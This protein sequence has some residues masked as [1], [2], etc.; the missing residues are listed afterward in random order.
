LIDLVIQGAAVPTFLIDRIAG[1]TGAQQISP[2]PPQAV[3]LRC[4]TRHPEVPALCAGERL[5]F[6][7]IA[8]GRRLADYGLLAMD[9]DSTLITIEC[10]DEVA[11][12]AG[13]KGEVSAI[14]EAAMRGEIDYT[15]SLKRRVGLLAGLPASIL[16]KV[17]EERLRLSTGARELLAAAQTAGLKTLLVSGGFTYFTERL[18]AELRLDAAFSNVLEVVDGQLTG[19]VLGDIVDARGK[20]R[21]VAAMRDSLGLARD[22]VIAIGDGANDLLMMAEAGLSVAYHAKPVAREE[23]TVALNYVGLDGLLNLFE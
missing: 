13:K 20:A 22:Q 10:I 19:R 16:G 5:D 7:Y 12:F 9:M 18:Q 15:E 4:V 11:D 6:A 3:R 14:T 17:F 23:A 2:Q 1:L 8:S 21:H